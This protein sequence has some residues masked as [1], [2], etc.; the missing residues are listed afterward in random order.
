MKKTLLF[1]FSALIISAFSYAYNYTAKK[2]HKNFSDTTQSAAG[3]SSYNPPPTDTS[4]TNPPA[5]TT[6]TPPPDTSYTP[7]PD[8][9][10]TP[11]DDTTSTPPADSTYTPPTDTTYTPPADTT[12]TPPA[13]TTYT[14][15]AD[16]TYTPPADTTYTPPADTTYTPPADTTYTPPGDTTSTPPNDTVSTP[17][18]GDTTVVTKPPLIS[19]PGTNSLK[20][21]ISDGTGGFIIVW[22]NIQF[23]DTTV[24][25]KIYAQRVS[26]T[27]NFMWGSEGIS[28]AQ[29]T[30]NQSYPKFISDRSG[31]VIIAWNQGSGNN[32]KVYAQRIDANGLRAWGD[33]GRAVTPDTG[34]H[35]LDDIV[36]IGDNGAF[37]SWF[38]KD[39]D[40]NIQLDGDGN[41]IGS[42]ISLSSDPNAYIETIIPGANG[43]TIV[44]FTIETQSGNETGYDHYVQRFSAQGQALLA[45]GGVKFISFP[46]SN[47]KVSDGNI[48]SDGSGGFFALIVDE[49]NNNKLYLQHVLST[50]ATAFS[51]YGLVVDESTKGKALLITDGSGG[52]IVSWADVRSASQT[53]ALGLKSSATTL[54]TT[55]STGYYAQRYNS[56]GDR[57]WNSADVTL[58]ASDVDESSDFTYSV[59]QTGNIVFV[60]PAVQDAGNSLYGQ[61]INLTGATQWTTSGVLIDGS[62]SFKSNP[63]VIITAD[64]ITVLYDGSSFTGTEIYSQVVSPD[65]VLPVNLKS[66]NALVRNQ[67]VHLSWN[68]V[69]E[70]NNDY[71]QIE[72]SEDGKHF[73]A[74]AKVIGKG[75]STSVQTYGF[76]DQPLVSGQQDLYYRIKQVD[77]D[78]AA[79]YSETVSVKLADLHAPVISVY[80]NP[81]SSFVNIELGESRNRFSYKLFDV[82]GK[83]VNSNTAE[84][85]RTTVELGSLNS[86]V[87][88]IQILSGDVKT[89]KKL[90]K[91]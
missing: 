82:N 29:S 66:F 60:I 72:R 63:S 90:I 16:T 7:P 11:P 45:E 35:H 71:F 88:F 91:Q 6:Y 69:S 76:I 14:P 40:G 30:Q 89:T 52:V 12:Y 44:I 25:T 54:A 74:I 43:E 2:L 27:Y 1:L 87:Y 33:T 77:K 58:K 65:G 75:N 10:Y 28:V 24:T 78:G 85:S 9:T 21:T 48:L 64:K 5:D 34:F 38:T 39:S 31:G 56:S 67:K 36:P 81:A 15:P 26:A 32:L 23:I 20:A 80:P 70:I 51:G 37:I 17:P 53:S 8:T 49:A 83:L 3:D 86:G 57:L 55:S 19:T 47:F 73:S 18:A 50:G 4:T 22:E 46:G 42:S 62:N 84:G 13:D 59:D 61:K 41:T 79:K 68:T